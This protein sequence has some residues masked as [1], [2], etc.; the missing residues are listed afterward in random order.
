M[1]SVRNLGIIMYSDLETEKQ[2]NAISKSCF[3]HIR[4][5]GKVRQYITYDAC[6][7]VVQALV[8]HHLD[9]GT[10]CC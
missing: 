3:Y 9:Y 4:N 10:R 1:P 7:I 2:V 8:T 6:N 5:S